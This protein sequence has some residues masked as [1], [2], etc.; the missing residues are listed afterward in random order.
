MPRAAKIDPQTILATFD[1]DPAT[2]AMYP[3]PTMAHTV[4]KT[5]ARQWQIGRHRYSLHRLVWAWH[6]PDHPNPKFVTFRDGVA[7]N[8]RIDNLC[9]T[10][11][12]PRWAEHLK[13]RRGYIDSMGYITFEDALDAKFDYQ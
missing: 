5:D 6:H 7:T 10:E 2:G 3:K 8:T 1:Y 12:H 4:R 9:A 13:Q 11:E